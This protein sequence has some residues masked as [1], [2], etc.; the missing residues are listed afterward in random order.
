MTDFQRFLK[1]FNPYEM[2]KSWQNKLLFILVVGIGLRA[3]SQIPLPGLNY[4]LL[5]PGKL[6]KP[7]FL[8]LGVLPFIQASILGQFLLSKNDNDDDLNKE[9]NTKKKIKLLSGAIALV[10]S[11]FKVKTFAPAMYSYTFLNIACLVLTLTT[12][13]L[14][15]V[16]VSEWLYEA[17]SLSGSVVVLCF[18]SIMDDFIRFFYQVLEGTYQGNVFFL[19]YVILV[20]FFATLYS[21]NTVDFPIRSSR[22]AYSNQVETD[23][24]S[25]IVNPGGV[26]ALVLSESL[27]KILSGFSLFNKASLLSLVGISFLRFIFIVFFSYYC[28]K[29]QVD[30][31]KVVKDLN[32]MNV[33]ILN[34]PPTKS[35]K[36]H[37][38]DL[39]KKAYINGGVILALLVGL[40]EILRIFYPVINLRENLSS[41]MIFFSLMYDL[42]DRI[43][44][45]VTFERNKN[46]EN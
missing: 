24:L 28:A 5:P 38:D 46:K 27:I 35:M 23:D 21:K 25:F 16:W 42:N 14:L 29:L 20:S 11:F 18:T 9:K 13:A 7:N 37:L 30:S 34:T 33:T 10:T 32:T 12:G 22:Q 43:F 15:L 40:A 45:F 41:L 2:E 19:V 1:R 39:L 26:T 36:E 44:R 6:L 31:E 8:E 3:L 4:S 17:L